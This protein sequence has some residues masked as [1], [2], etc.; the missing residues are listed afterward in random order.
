M[1]EV[2]VVSTLSQALPSLCV[3]V[4]MSLSLSLSPSCSLPEQPPQIIINIINKNERQVIKYK[5]CRV[6]PRARRAVH[7][8][9]GLILLPIQAVDEASL[10]PGL[11]EAVNEVQERDDCRQPLSCRGAQRGVSALSLQPLHQ[12]LGIPKSKLLPWIHSSATQ[13]LHLDSL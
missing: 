4:A 8:R 11:I 10:A 1:T 2:R 3:E 7:K 6:P 12:G 5:I 9:Y 13:N